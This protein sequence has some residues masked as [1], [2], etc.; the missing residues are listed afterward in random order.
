[1]KKL[2]LVL[3]MMVVFGI[4]GTTVLAGTVDFEG[5]PQ[6]YWFYG[7]Q[8]N[9]GTYWAG[10]NFGPQATVLEDQVYGY[11]SAGYPPH[12]GH[13][14]L[15]S[16]STPSIRVDFNSPVDFVSLWYTSYSNFYLDAYD[17]LNNLI[18]QATGSSNIGTNSF[19]Q[20]SSLSSNIDYIIMH[21]SGNYFTVDDLSAPILTGQPTNGAIPEPATML[22]LGSGLVGLAG[23]ARRR[24][25]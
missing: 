15:F 13:A 4:C 5:V 11:N 19:L 14:V 18:D 8:Q 9:F 16:I 17:S 1:M 23:Y 6:T 21:D 3:T 20:V 22:L 12:S 2:F 25:K 10:A 7:G 24:F